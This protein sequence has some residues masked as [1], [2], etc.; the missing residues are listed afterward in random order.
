MTVRRTIVLGGCV[1]T[2]RVCAE[3][4]GAFWVGRRTLNK[5]VRQA[6]VQSSPLVDALTKIIKLKL[7][8]VVCVSMVC[9]K[10]GISNETSNQSN[11]QT[12][13]KH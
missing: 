4:P 7:Q 9:V 3:V 6:A 10:K 13:K 2:R 1:K 12:N 8:Q 11:K 5:L